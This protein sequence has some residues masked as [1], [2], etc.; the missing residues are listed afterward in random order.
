[1]FFIHRKDAIYRVSISTTCC[2]IKYSVYVARKNGLCTGI[3]F[4]GDTV[5][6]RDKAC[7]V[8]TNLFI[9]KIIIYSIKFYYYKISANPANLDKILV[10]KFIAMNVAY[11]RHAVHIATF[12]STNI[13]PRRGIE[14]NFCL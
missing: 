2:I 8:S 13:L 12:N 5:I 4:V 11:L 3:C 1:M 14:K 6:R 9:Q 7:L 10:Q